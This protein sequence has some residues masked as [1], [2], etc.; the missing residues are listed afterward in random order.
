MSG[1]NRTSPLPMGAVVPSPDADPDTTSDQADQSKC[2]VSKAKTIIK[3]IFAQ[4]FSHLG[5][6]LL[7]VGYSLMGAVIFVSLEKQ[8]E[9]DTRN[10]VSSTRNET[11][12]E[13]YSLT[14]M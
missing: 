14:G 12:N 4:L 5:L 13:L 2:T 7:V 3:T 9:L 1:S 11:L 6:C 10:K 8:H